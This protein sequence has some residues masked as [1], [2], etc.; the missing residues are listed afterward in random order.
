MLQDNGNICLGQPVQ[1]VPTTV[2][3]A[4]PPSM[5]QEHPVPIGADSMSAQVRTEV[6]QNPPMPVDA[7]F[8]FTE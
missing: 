4:R 8:W 6:A 2:P 5:R 7:E 3:R 1:G